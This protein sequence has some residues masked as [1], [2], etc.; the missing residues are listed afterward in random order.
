MFGN[1]NKMIKEGQ[2]RWDK[3]EKLAETINNSTTDGQVYDDAIRE[4]IL[5]V[6]EHL[7]PMNPSKEQINEATDG[8]TN[9][10]DLLK[11]LK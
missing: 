10:A 3:I 6:V 11:N 7:R 2:E 5:L 9:L 8:L 4:L 1:L